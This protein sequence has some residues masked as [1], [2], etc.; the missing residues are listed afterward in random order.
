MN[1]YFSILIP[2][3]NQVGKMTRCIECLK[4]QSF[5]DFEVIFVD[6]GSTDDSW[7]LLCDLEKEDS[8]F[9]AYR[10]EGNKSLLTARF[11][12]MSHAE[13]KYI[14]FLDS[15]DYFENRTCEVLHGEL[16]KDPVDV[17]MF[18]TIIE[19]AGEK[20]PAVVTDDPLRSSLDGSIT[21]S[22]WKNC[23][24][25]KVV[26][27][28]VKRVSP[29]YCNMSEDACLSGMFFSCAESYAK[30]D[31]LLYHYESGGMSSSQASRSIEKAKKDLASVAAAGDH[32][33][34]YIEE[35]RPD[36]LELAKQAA[37]RMVIFVLFQHV[38]FEQDWVRVFEYMELFNNEKYRYAFEFGCNT[39]FP[40]K[41]KKSMGIE[42]GR[43][44][45]G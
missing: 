24:S 7:R 4:N 39:L 23:Y 1:P 32:L 21:P 28:V 35:Y 45:F 11:T 40:N 33:C 6:D 36:Y 30:T 34:A 37:R 9:R 27:T 41:V 15:D 25:R 42:V 18:G 29:F 31:E 13:G 8:R 2:V 12:G 17:L 44:S 10:H 22:I 19:P 20:L 43:F 3:Y 26:D 38:Y 16:E 14:L 5:E